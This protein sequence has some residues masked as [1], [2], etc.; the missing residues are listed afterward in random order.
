[1]E[2]VATFLKDSDGDGVVDAEEQGPNG[3]DSAYDGNNDGVADYL[4]RKCV[5]IH[6]YDQEAYVTFECDKGNITEIR[7]IENPSPDNAPD[8]AY[9][10]IGFYEFNIENMAANDRVMVVLHLSETLKMD[11]YFKFGPTPDN[12]LPHWYEFK[13]DSKTGIGAE[14]SGSI[15]KLHFVDGARG[16]SD[17]KS[18]GTITDPGAPGTAIVNPGGSGGGSGDGSGSSDSGGG[19]GGCFITTMIQ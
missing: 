15:I 16:D 11:T 9:F 1:M 5:S 17:L 12:S 10:P 6:S 13:Y 8:G 4:Q 3:N 2:V 7:S 18:N 14:F 19:G